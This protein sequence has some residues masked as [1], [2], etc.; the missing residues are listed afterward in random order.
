MIT[1][2]EMNKYIKEK[3]IINIII[4]YSNKKNIQNEIYDSLNY[5]N[6]LYNLKNRKKLNNYK[7]IIK[8]LKRRKKLKEYMINDFR[9]KYYKC[10][11]DF[12]FKTNN[13]Y[14]LNDK[15]IDFNWR[16]ITT[17]MI[18]SK[19]ISK[20]FYN[21]HK[22]FLMKYEKRIFNYLNKKIKLI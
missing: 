11:T 15:R 22:K 13:L 16:K 12:I 8:S 21:K 10:Q 19:A 5:Y 1:Y 6:K 4:K 17:I 7:I 18:K 3:N 20:G 9:I 2:N 14:L